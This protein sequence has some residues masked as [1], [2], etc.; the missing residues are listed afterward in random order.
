MLLGF[1]DSKV[2]DQAVICDVASYRQL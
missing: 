1:I 2:C